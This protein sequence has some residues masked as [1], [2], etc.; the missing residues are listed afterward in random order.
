MSI[1]GEDLVQLGERG[2][3]SGKRNGCLGKVTN[4]SRY[5]HRKRCFS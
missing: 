3:R 2:R 4:K 5:R 1:I